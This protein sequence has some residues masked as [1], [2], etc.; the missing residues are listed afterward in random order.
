MGISVAEQLILD[1]LNKIEQSINKI[2]GSVNV[3]RA[4]NQEE[5][6]R[7]YD[8]IAKVETKSEEIHTQTTKT[9]GR[10]TRLEDKHLVCQVAQ[11]E[12]RVLKIEQ[13]NEIKKTTENLKATDE[14]KA[15]ER[16]KN[17]YKAAIW[18][19]GVVTAGG[20]IISGFAYLKDVL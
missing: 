20:V 2:E 1:Q 18:I 4:E 16:M 8:K 9:N 14:Y 5:F 7:V 15:G 13:D 6:R 17:F 11:V 3:L 10:V 19:V 12:G